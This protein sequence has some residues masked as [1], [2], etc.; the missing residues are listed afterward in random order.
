MPAFITESEV[1]NLALG[2]LSDLGY[3]VLY[4]PT[5]EPEQPAQERQDFG[6]VVLVGRLRNALGKLNPQASG[7]SL[8]DAMRQI[9]RV[10]SPSLVE[11]N[12]S[13]HR[14]VT[15]GVSVPRRKPDG[16]Q[17]FQQLRLL[18]HDDPESNDFLAV[19]QFTVLENKNHR[20]PDIVIFVNGLPLAVFEMKNPADEKATAKSA[21][22]QL[23]TY[24][25]QIPTLFQFNELLIVS[26][27]L[28]TKVG[29]LTANWE[30]FLPWRTAD[31]KT[32][33]PKTELQ[34]KT[35]VQ[36]AFDKARLLDL[37]RYFVVFDTSVAPP[38]KKI[39][40][41]HQFGAVNKA[42]ECTLEAS[43]PDGDRRAG[44][45]WHTQGS[46]KSLSMAFYAGKMVQHPTMENPTV[47]VLTDR[48]DLDD[49][50]FGT[51][52]ACQGLLR[53]AP[54]QAQSRDHLRE[55]LKVGSGGVVFATIQKFFPNKGERYPQLSDRR[56]VVVIADEAHRS[57]YDFIDGFAR[58]M[59]DALP[60]A[61][62]IG[63]TGTPIELSDKST[64]AVFG[65][66]IDVYD[67]R[68]AV[69]DGATV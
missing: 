40:A 36:G 4:G 50:L 38:V 47:V 7:E 19:N 6:Q 44:V 37:I 58:H 56:N 60:N 9:L 53:Q 13:F 42:V 22:K 69:E 57:Q 15:D 67:V 27:G 55:L 12:R 2:Y 66:Y 10:D 64:P 3:E 14:M 61:S 18:D 11:T 45:V 54:Q 16:T 29:S 25:Q 63:F 51:F 34:L 41:Y 52:S 5:I 62:F 28:T 20:R 1:E 30:W 39:A 35:L 59:R 33:A 43:R 26:D 32:V 48:N 49:Q 23:Q 65:N 8:D 24:K 46:G 21:F 31:G 17:G 68:R